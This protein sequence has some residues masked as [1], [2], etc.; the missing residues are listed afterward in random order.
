[1]GWRQALP[2]L[3]GAVMFAV[4]LWVLHRTLARYNLGQV[5]DE[6]SALKPHQVLLALLFTGLSFVSLIGYEVSSLRLIGRRRQVS[7]P[8]LA[9]AS[10][11]TQSICHS[12][13][14]AFVIG[15]TLR[16]QFYA[17]R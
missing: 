11:V 7:F 6:L 4:A 2:F 5:Q 15:A 13:G 10:F 1:R 3:L 12:T 9:L 8:L 16:Y 17:K 14:F